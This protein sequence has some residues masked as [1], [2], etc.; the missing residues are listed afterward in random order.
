MGPRVM[1][2]KYSRL[3]AKIKAVALLV[4]WVSSRSSERKPQ[5]H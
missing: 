4:E 3:A 2:G 1:S 5:R